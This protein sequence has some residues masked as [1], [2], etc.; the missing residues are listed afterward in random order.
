MTD[1]TAFRAEQRALAR[2]WQ[3]L[4]HAGDVAKE[5]DW[6]RTVLGGEQVFVQR[7]REGLCG[8]VNRCAHRFHPIRTAERGNGPVV[9]PFHEWR[10]DHSGLAFGIPRCREVFGR[11]PKELNARLTSIELATAGGLIFGR[12]GSGPDLGHWLGPGQSILDYLGRARPLSL[13]IDSMIAAHWTLV[14]QITLDDYHLVGVHPSTFGRHGYLETDILRYFRFAPHS[15]YFTGQDEGALDRMAAECAAGTW[16]LDC[17]RIMQFFPN[18]VVVLFQ[19]PLVLGKRYDFMV[20]LHIEP[21]AHDRTRLVKRFFSLGGAGSYLH[22]ALA[23]F[24]NTATWLIARRIQG[25]DNA[26]VERLQTTAAG[27]D[28]P[29]L[30]SAQETRIAWFDEDYARLIGS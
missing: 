29:P 24:V 7:F 20:V 25:E 3:F 21:L 17:Y 13:R 5:G 1:P 8:F 16:K 6:F 23:P 22:R 9:C 30:I 28:A 11:S 15:A 26:C 18:L 27:I 12:H 2:H 10:Y 4:G 14:M 19:T